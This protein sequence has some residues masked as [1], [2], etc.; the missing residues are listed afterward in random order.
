MYSAEGSAFTVF[1]ENDEI[2]A[3]EEQFWLDAL[4]GKCSVP[5]LPWVDDGVGLPLL[6]CLV[7]TRRPSLWELWGTESGTPMQ[8]VSPDVVLQQGLPAG[9][10]EGAQEGLQQQPRRALCPHGWGARRVLSRYKTNG[11]SGPHAR[12]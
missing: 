2:G 7:S 1:H 5:L 9:A 11:L 10:L 4:R 8:S 6:F 12:G 3:E